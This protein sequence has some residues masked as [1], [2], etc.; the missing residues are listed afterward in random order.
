MLILVGLVSVEVLGPWL[1]L[2]L[3]DDR[4]ETYRVETY[5]HSPRALLAL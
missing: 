4:V 2:Y 5:L 3:D 1:K